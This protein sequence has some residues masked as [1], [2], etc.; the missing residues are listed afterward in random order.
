MIISRIKRETI[1]VLSGKVRLYIGKDMENLEQF[2][3]M[4]AG[5]RLLKKYTIHRM[6]GI[7][8]SEY[9]ENVLHLNYGML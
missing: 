2:H 7:E 8:D 4:V 3:Q 6:E 5:D 9:L 1:Y